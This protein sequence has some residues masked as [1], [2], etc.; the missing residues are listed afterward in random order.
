M[1]K[2]KKRRG[3]TL[4]ELLMVVAIIAILSTIILIALNSSR[5][6]ASAS[7]YISYATQMHRLTA[8]AIAAGYLDSGVLQTGFTPGTAYCFGNI[9]ECWNGA[10]T[11]S[12]QLDNA[13]TKLGEYPTGYDQDDVHSPYNADYGVTVGMKTD[14]SAMRLQMYLLEGDLPYVQKICNSM[15]WSVCASNTSCCVDLSLSSRLRQ[16][17]QTGGAASGDGL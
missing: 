9:D 8:D 11:F 14:N 4:I 1:I 17:G 5:E 3:F 16:Q 10:N 13:L 7:K 12:S 6:K 15:N 2:Q